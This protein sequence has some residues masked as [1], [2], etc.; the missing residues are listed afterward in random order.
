MPKASFQ[1]DEEEQRLMSDHPEVNWSAVFRRTIREQVETLELARQL[2]EERLPQARA[3]GS[4]LK[5]G[6][7]RRWREALGNSGKGKTGGRRSS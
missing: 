4:E 2:R 6:T 7:G 5:A 1:L 3:V